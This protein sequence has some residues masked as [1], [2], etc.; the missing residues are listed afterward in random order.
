MWTAKIRKLLNLQRVQR[1][2]TN[3]AE[4]I[5]RFVRDLLLP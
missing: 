4:P 3:G 1:N 5:G 2:E